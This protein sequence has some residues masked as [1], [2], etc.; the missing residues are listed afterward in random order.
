MVVKYY[1]LFQDDS[2]QLCDFKPL[3]I[4]VCKCAYTKL[5]MYVSLYVSY[6]IICVCLCF[7]MFCVILW[8]C[9]LVYLYAIDLC[10][11]IYMLHVFL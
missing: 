10:A 2:Y 9:S 5:H 4:S 8:I 3:S 1:I 6:V 11:G 7:T